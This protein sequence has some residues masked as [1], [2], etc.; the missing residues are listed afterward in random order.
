M[1]ISLTCQIHTNFLNLSKQRSVNMLQNGLEKQNDRMV[2]EWLI[3]L[4]T[5]TLVV[6]DLTGELLTF[7]FSLVSTKSRHMTS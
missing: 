4:C 5:Y 2:I 1:G 3:H 6:V 7:T